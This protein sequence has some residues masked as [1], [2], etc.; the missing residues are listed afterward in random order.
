MVGEDYKIARKVILRNLKGSS[1]FKNK[2][3]KNCV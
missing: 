3:W 2:A 1:A